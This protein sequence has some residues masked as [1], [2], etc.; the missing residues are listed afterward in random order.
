MDE[1]N[2]TPSMKILNDNQMEYIHRATLQVLEETG[3]SIKHPK[4]LDILAGAGCR[5]DADRVYFPPA[6]VEKA[7]STAPKRV[8]F[9]NR[10]N[11][12][13]IVL[14]G[15]NTYFGATIDC[16][17]YLDPE[18]EELS[19]CRSQN[20]VAM[21]KLCDILDHYDWI[22]TLGI[23]RDLPES[24][25]DRGVARI[26]LEHC[27]KPVI[28]SCN[29]AESLR[30]IYEMAR[31]C[32]GGGEEDFNQ[33]PLLGTLNC[34][35][36][37]LMHDDH[38]VGKNIFAAEKG[39]PIVHYSGMQLGG[40]FPATLASGVVM[41]SAESL[42]G[43]VLQQIIN[44]G[45]P[46][47]FGGFIT[48]MDMKTTVFS[49]GAIE[50]AMMVG[51]MA[52]LAQKYQLPFFGTAGC[53]DAKKVDIQAAAEGSLQDL[54]MATVGGGMVHDT[55][56]WLDHGSI[57]S[58]AHLVLGQEILGMVK[59]F[60]GGITVSEDTL[61]L[62]LIHKIGPGGTFLL[63]PHTLKHF[64][65]IFYPELFQRTKSQAPGTRI[66]ET[67]EDR[68][69]ART[70]ELMKAAPPNPLSDDIVQAFDRRWKKWVA[71]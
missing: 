51:A 32:R 61:A 8:V 33:A 29:D 7:L 22:M 45:A 5:V 62:D 2:F 17:N 34:T 49:Y 30:E 67:I 27:S 3:V 38:L 23:A 71:S 24:A 60:T 36:S 42:S 68:L 12:R 41:G 37:P 69:R 11:S 18:T 9:G 1:L 10:D 15:A 56:C 48:I 16:V 26:A 31:L 28:V 39:I 40:S 47:V 6:L 21:A 50:M 54:I 64:K 65:S 58:P 52:Q 35:I 57:L 63:D 66:E 70:L 59:K 19:E 13:R 20:V 44:P 53:T 55:H 4:A 46:F 14:E 43:L 25:A